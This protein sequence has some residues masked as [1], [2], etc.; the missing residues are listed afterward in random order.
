ML[1]AVAVLWVIY[2]IRG[3]LAPFGLAFVLAYVLAPVVDRM[4][5]RGLERTWSILLV[6]VMVFSGLGFGA[7]KVGGKLTGE[8]VELSDGFM[9]REK[10]DK[11]F[12][13]KNNRE[14]PLVVE[15][16]AWE[17]ASETKP[18]ALLNIKDLP[19]E[20]ES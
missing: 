8:M 10:I 19:F 5:G 11:S 13:I 1:V 16:I 9:R 7:F 6:F 15:N 12:V 20:I 4:E 2:Q 14:S 3:V 17:D 18:F